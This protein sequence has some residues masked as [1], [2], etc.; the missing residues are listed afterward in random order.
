MSVPCA[1]ATCHS[2]N[3]IVARLKNYPFLVN[4]TIELKTI[5]TS[6]NKI[7]LKAIF[8]KKLQNIKWRHS[9]KYVFLCSHIWRPKCFSLRHFCAM[10]T[11][12]DVSLTTFICEVRIFKTSREST[13]QVLTR[14]YKLLPC[15]TLNFARCHV[16]CKLFELM[17]PVLLFGLLLTYDRINEKIKQSDRSFCQISWHSFFRGRALFLKFREI[18]CVFAIFSFDVSSQI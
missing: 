15:F 11:Y 14:S 8:S 2:L 16:A 9:C 1:Q 17:T 10:K 4:T 3:A 6:N 13:L 5:T 7:W 18:K 12:F